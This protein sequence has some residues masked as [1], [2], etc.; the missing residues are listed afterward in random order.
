MA[1][2]TIATKTLSKVFTDALPSNDQ[3]HRLERRMNKTSCHRK[4]AVNGQAAAG[5]GARSSSSVQRVVQPHGL[6]WMVIHPTENTTAT[7][8]RL[9]EYDVLGLYW[10]S[11]NGFKRTLGKKIYAD[12]NDAKKAT[13]CSEIERHSKEM[14]LLKAELVRLNVQS[15]GTR[16]Q[17]T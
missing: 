16:D 4:G 14:K 6:N 13:V 12:E 17:K 11:E 7:Q 8:L 5:T 9:G 15:S 2:N 10:H 3:A 1:S